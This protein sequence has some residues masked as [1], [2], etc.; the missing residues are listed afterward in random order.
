VDRDRVGRA[1]AAIRSHAARDA[2][3]A[4]AAMLLVLGTSEGIATDRTLVAGD[5]FDERRAE[6][7]QA[8]GMISVQ[9]GMGVEEALTRL[10][11]HAYAEDRRL[12]DVA[13]DVVARRLRFAPEPAGN[14]AG[15]D[16]DGPGKEARS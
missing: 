13:R 8:A 1:W 2:T 7:H 16:H 4:D 3:N 6:V 12:A 14:S 15:D 5:G 11:A 9:L 10:R